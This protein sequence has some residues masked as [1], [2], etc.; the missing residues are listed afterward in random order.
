MSSKQTAVVKR[1]ETRVVHLGKTTE[2]MYNILNYESGTKNSKTINNR[3]SVIRCSHIH[4][5]L[6]LFP[7]H[8]HIFQLYCERM[9]DLLHSRAQQPNFYIQ[10]RCV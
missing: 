6:T 2:Q 1:E 3:K 8:S 9:K 5:D 10:Q 7:H 4:T